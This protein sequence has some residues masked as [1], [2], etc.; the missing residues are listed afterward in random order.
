VLDLRHNLRSRLKGGK[1]QI[2]FC[3][4]FSWIHFSF[5]LVVDTCVLQ[6][7]I[8]TSGET[9]SASQVFS[10]GLVVRV[11]WCDVRVEQWVCPCATN[12]SVTGTEIFLRECQGGYHRRQKF[13]SG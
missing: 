5:P 10:K 1:E 8:A 2:D 3:V 7:P 4:L 13:I 6:P 12:G 9:A 11:F